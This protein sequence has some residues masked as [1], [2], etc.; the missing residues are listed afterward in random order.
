MDNYISESNLNAQLTK[1]I[2]WNETKNHNEKSYCCGFAESERY[3]GESIHDGLFQFTII[4]SPK[5]FDKF[6]FRLFNT[7][8]FTCNDCI[9]STL[10]CSW[11]FRRSSSVSLISFMTFSFLKAI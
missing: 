4:L 11:A 10:F 5:S 9:R 7:I 6:I 2:R 8:N 3:K 1:F